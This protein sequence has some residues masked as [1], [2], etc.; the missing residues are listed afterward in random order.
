LKPA[1]DDRGAGFFATM[2]TNHFY[3]LIFL[4]VL[5]P[6]VNAEAGL[7]VLEGEHTVIYDIVNPRGVAFIPDY[8]NESFEQKVISQ[9]EFSKRVQVNNEDASPEDSCPLSR[10]DRFNPVNGRTVPLA[11]EGQAIG[12][13]VNRAPGEGIGPGKQV[14]A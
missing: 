12:R 3:A 4:F 6:A 14:R 10:S 8:S 13:S 7:K 11:R 5:A 2:L 1:P 9:D